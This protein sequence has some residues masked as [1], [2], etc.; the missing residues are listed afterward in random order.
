M[1]DNKRRRIVVD[2]EAD[3]DMDDRERFVN[4][5][6]EY[7]RDEDNESVG[8]NPDDFD[9]EVD[10]DEGEGED[11]AETWD[12][13]VALLL[14][15]TINHIFWIYNFTYFHLLTEIM[16]FCL[17]SIVTKILNWRRTPTSV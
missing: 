3:N 12:K 1:S 2:D 7:K 11:L 6:D 16:R 15:V 9:E 13:Y 17:S 10:E 5:S 8:S 14:I 4:V